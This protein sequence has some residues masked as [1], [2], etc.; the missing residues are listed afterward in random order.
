MMGY[1]CIQMIKDLV[2]VV[3]SYWGA[4]HSCQIGVVFVNWGSA[5][6]GDKCGK[7]YKQAESVRKP[8]LKTRPTTIQIFY[9]R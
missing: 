6:G 1:P 2:G 5:W 3:I 8:V 4:P 7:L 9:F